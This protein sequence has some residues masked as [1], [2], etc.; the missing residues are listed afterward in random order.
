MLLLVS[1]ICV[2]G[3]L[4]MRRR[5]QTNK[6]PFWTAGEVTRG[7]WHRGEVIWSRIPNAKS[8][9]IQAKLVPLTALLVIGD[10][11]KGSGKKLM[12]RLY[13]DQGRVV[14]VNG[15]DLRWLRTNECRNYVK[16]SAFLL[17]NQHPAPL[18]PKALS[19]GVSA[20]SLARSFSCGC[21][22]IPDCWQTSCL[23]CTMDQLYYCKSCRSAADG[24]DKCQ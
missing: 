18:D 11:T 9:D 10:R 12:M 16:H 22:I 3:H 21:S 24:V 19:T 7:K 15:M 8:S 17:H 5:P 14:K 2:L 4:T 20:C 6:E 23:Y 13:M 1:R